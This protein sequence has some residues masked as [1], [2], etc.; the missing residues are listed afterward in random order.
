LEPGRDPLLERGDRDQALDGH[1]LVVSAASEVV[2]D[3]YVVAERT[4]MQGCRPA[5]V[6]VT[7]KNQDLH[8]GAPAPVR[9]VN[10]IFSALAPWG[11]G[12]RRRPGIPAACERTRIADRT[13]E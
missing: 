13:S 6:S 3:G 4:Q 12:G 7:A 9:W 10:G 2:V 5:Q 11:R 1:L 8:S